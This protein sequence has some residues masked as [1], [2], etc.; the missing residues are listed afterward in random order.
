MQRDLELLAAIGADDQRSLR[1]VALSRQLPKLDHYQ[2]LDLPRAATRN[3][4]IAQGEE[5][6]RRYDPATFPPAAREA[7]QAITRR[8]EE[9]VNTLREPAQRQAYDRMGQQRGSGD[10]HQR[11]TQRS[12]A[13]QNFAHAKELV[14]KGDYYGAILLLQQTVSFLPDHAEAWFLLGTCQERNPHWRREAAESM[15]R[16]LSADPNHID[17]MIALGDIYRSG[18]LVARA[19]SCYE[20]ALKISPDNQQAKSRLQMMKKR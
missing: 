1:A 10:M 15:Q 19:Q 4:I 16:A 7:L 9:A 20:D 13:E 12:I 5:L 2:L 6:K 3:Q 17:A 8:I 18:G 14:V 11:A